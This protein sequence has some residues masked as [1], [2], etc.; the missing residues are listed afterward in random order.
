MGVG[1]VLGAANG[2]TDA[3]GTPNAGGNALPAPK[4]ENMVGRPNAG[5]GGA[6]PPNG[7]PTAVGAAAAP[8]PAVA[9]GGLNA[10]VAGP[11]PN[12]KPPPEPKAID[13]AAAPNPL[14]A[15]FP[16]AN[17][18]GA[19]GMVLSVAGKTGPN[20]GNAAAGPASLAFG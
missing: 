10:G 12:A 2:A 11:A 4:P 16:N 3:A 17:A 18:F 19:A 13:G 15:G 8:N 6:A 14:S 9:G 5:V 1:A 20:A 7:E